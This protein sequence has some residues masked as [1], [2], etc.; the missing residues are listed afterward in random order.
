M[1]F[2]PLPAQALR[3]LVS[4]SRDTIHDL[5]L[6]G[7][8]FS[9]SLRRIKNCFCIWHRPLLQ[10]IIY[11]LNGE[12]CGWR[13]LRLL[14]PS[15]TTPP[16]PPTPPSAN[17]PNATVGVRLFASKMWGFKS[18]SGWKEWKKIERGT[19]IRLRP[20]YSQLLICRRP[21]FLSVYV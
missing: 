20:Q 17:T 12:H 1:G 11:R 13:S 3:S 15:S 19:L 2:K 21:Y 10:Y 8:H 5:S 14:P 7:V 16:D 4:G 9:L 6:I 18:L